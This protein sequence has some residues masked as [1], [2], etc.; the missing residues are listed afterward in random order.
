[1]DT[2]HQNLGKKEKNHIKFTIK[3]PRIRGLGTFRINYEVL[4]SITDVRKVHI[5]IKT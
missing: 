5:M 2:N 1:M 4:G 3:G